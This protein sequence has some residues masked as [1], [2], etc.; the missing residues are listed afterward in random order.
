V[1]VTVSVGG[2]GG[3][4][5]GGA[6]SVGGGAGGGGGG[7][8]VVVI[9]SCTGGVVTVVVAGVAVFLVSRLVTSNATEATSAIAATIAVMPTTQGHL[10]GGSSSPA[11]DCS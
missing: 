8:V 4:G 9:W 11:A 2:G 10:G 6:T 1:T 7:G 3:G 5:G